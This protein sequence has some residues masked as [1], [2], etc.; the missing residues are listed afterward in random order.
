MKLLIV[1]MHLR[2]FEARMGTPTRQ[3]IGYSTLTQEEESF[4]QSVFERVSSELFSLA[5]A[6]LRQGHVPSVAS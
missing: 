2:S 6:L 1:G 3:N 4:L 5:L